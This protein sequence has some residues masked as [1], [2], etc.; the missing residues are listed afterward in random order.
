MATIA[1]K[2]LSD[3]SITNAK[4]ASGAAIDVTKLGTGSVN[5][6]EFGYLDGVTSS[7]QTQLNDKANTTLSNLTSP[8]A[9]NQDLNLNAGKNILLKNNTYINAYKVDGVTIAPLLRLDNTDVCQ[10]GTGSGQT[11]RLNAGIFAPTSNGNDLGTASLAWDIY[12]NNVLSDIKI[13]GTRT[14][15]TLDAV[16]TAALTI[17]TGTATTGTSGDLQLRTGNSSSGTPGNIVLQPGAVS[18]VRSN[19]NIVANSLDATGYTAFQLIVPKTITAGGTTG[20]QT[21]NR[22]SGTVNFSAAATALTV[23]NSLVT[24]NSIV[25]AVVR[26]NDATATIKNVV[27]AAGSFTINLNAAATAETSVGFFVVN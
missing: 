3:N 11:V 7:I 9:I 23:T 27:P 25:M 14:M 22:M 18:S 16:S 5:N 17:T 26:T 1:N 4:I 12:I 19:V 8:T 21:I 24:A 6:T 13:S 15:Q 20:N 2:F 10:I